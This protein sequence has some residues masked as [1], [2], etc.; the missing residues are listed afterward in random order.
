M[1]YLVIVLPK[2]TEIL[3]GDLNK[4]AVWE[5]IW[6]MKFHPGK[7]V[8][9]T[10]SSKKTPIQADYNLHG[11]I[12][13]RVKSAKYLGV[14]I[15]DD[16]KWD[17]HIQSICDKANRTIGFLRRN[18]NIGATAI[19]EKAYFTLVR[20]LVEYASTVW[21][22]HTQ[23]NI[24]KLEMVQRRAARYVKSRHRNLSSVSD[25]LTTLNWRS[26]Q[27]RRKDARLCMM[28][29]IDRN[30]VAIKKENRLT[31]PKK[32]TR[33][34]HNRAYQV[35]SCRIDRRKMSFFPRTL[36]DWNAL[37]PDIVE[38]ETLDAFKAQVSS[39]TY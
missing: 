9:L 30:L 5:D 35:P 37:P 34:S 26:L 18:L 10:V 13:S 25:L 38:A 7:C 2:D 32:R 15:T 20:P 28:Y 39:L 14:T 23:S 4:L 17:S 3:Q 12:L 29:K 21:D 27:D 33:H 16:L 31:P 24:H 19:K 1:A 6:D 8:V 22:P 36:K 11:H